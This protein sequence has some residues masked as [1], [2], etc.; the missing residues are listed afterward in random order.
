M[1]VGSGASWRP[2]GNHA[3]GQACQRLEQRLSHLLPNAA[4]ASVLTLDVR[5]QLAVGTAPATVED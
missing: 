2:F 1:G 4:S 3:I 5:P